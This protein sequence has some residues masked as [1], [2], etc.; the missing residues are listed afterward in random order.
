MIRHRVK[1]LYSALTAEVHA[2]ENA[3][4]S[5]YLADEERE[6]FYRM[7]VV[8]QR[9]AL[10]TC[11]KVLEGLARRED[12]AQEVLVVKAAL[13][14]DIGKLD[15]ELTILDRAI[16]VLLQQ[17]APHKI[18]LWACEGR[19]RFM[20][21]RRHALFLAAHHGE[22]GAGF[23]QEIGSETDLI[24]LVRDHH[25]PVERGWR[26]DLLRDADSKS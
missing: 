10:D 4:V 1:Q 17:F 3:I 21:N 15:G 26:M 20:Q 12:G 24:D 14:H 11:Y 22:R 9:H 5:R 2:E 18:E 7:S 19:G 6:L 25:R 16:I 13:L 8:D 23:L